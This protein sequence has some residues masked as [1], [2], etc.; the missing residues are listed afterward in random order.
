MCGC[1]NVDRLKPYPVRPDREAPPGPVSD[2]GQEGEYVV[3][4]LLNRCTLHGRTP[5]FGAVAGPRLHRRLLGASGAPDE[6]PGAHR[7]VRGGRPASPPPAAAGGSRSCTTGCGGRPSA[8]AR[9]PPRSTRLDGGPRGTC[10]SRRGSSLLVA[11]R[12]LAARPGGPP[13]C[14]RTLLPRRSLP[15]TYRIVHWGRGHAARLLLLRPS[16]GASRAACGLRRPEK[17]ATVKVW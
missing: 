1:L 4:Q 3:E 9:F 16:L 17:L 12:G 10:S 5:L 13:H 7:R 15:A 14:P 2:P 11:D 8:R 6:L